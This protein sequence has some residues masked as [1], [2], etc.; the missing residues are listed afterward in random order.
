MSNNDSPQ[1]PSNQQNHQQKNNDEGHDGSPYIG[2][3]I[4]LTTKHEKS[5]AIAPIIQQLLGANIVEFNADT[6]SLGTFSGEVER[7]GTPLE[8]VK[9]KCQWAL[10]ETKYLYA[11]ASEG[12]FGPHPAVPFVACNTETLY[13]IDK[14][15]NLDVDVT[16][17]FTET[18]Y[19]M[20]E[21]SSLEQ[22]LE[23]ADKA[24]FPS[25]GLIVRPLPKS[26]DLPIFKGICDRDD[27]E[28]AYRSARELSVAGKV[29]VETDMRAHLNPTRMANIGKLTEQL[30]KRLKSLCPKC[31]SPGWGRINVKRGLPCRWCNTPTEMVLVEIY[32]CN[33]CGHQAELPR[34]DGEET[35]DP[36]ACPVCNP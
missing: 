29:W 35:A 28:A 1:H 20:T 17:L 21:V 14:A 15:R 2:C 8:T 24:L 33:Q 25:H 12:S 6:D 34:S 36:G 11:L 22:L 18:N 23:F 9:K 30:A 26:N 31:Q 7:Q 19:Q 16:E 10:D 32:G 4:V 5:L 3:E 13:F 27:L